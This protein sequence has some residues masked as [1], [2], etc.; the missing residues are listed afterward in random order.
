MTT[1]TLR[2]CVEC[3]AA[4]SGERCKR[5]ERS[6]LFAAPVP[7][8]SPIEPPTK[9]HSC[10]KCAKEYALEV[11]G[12]CWACDQAVER[13]KAREVALERAGLRGWH[14]E[15][16][17]EHPKVLHLFDASAAVLRGRITKMLH[18]RTTA[19]AITI[20]GAT[21][22]GKSTLA[23][24]LAQARLSGA[25]LVRT[26]GL[27]AAID[28]HPLGEGTAPLMARA[29]SVPTLILDELVVPAV[30][31]RKE[32]ILELLF[33]RDA[34][35][36]LTVVTHGFREPEINADW[37]AGMHRRLYV[38]AYHLH[39][40]CPRCSHEAHKG[41]CSAKGCSCVRHRVIS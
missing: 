10:P 41:A 39:L 6:A 19:P 15:L 21:G 26:L 37:G 25:L 8:T 38:D 16:S 40:V 20:T 5:C 30:A 27:V 22:A 7:F 36:L 18:T 4:T 28:E 11:D 29:R 35:G 33:E 23:A 24:L 34:A 9:W 32:K 13:A 14:A 1:E 3:K 12:Q 17:V 31:S 2:A